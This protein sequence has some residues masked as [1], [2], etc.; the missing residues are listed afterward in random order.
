MVSSIPPAPADARISGVVPVAPRRISVVSLLSDEVFS[1][2]D[3][4][5]ADV[6]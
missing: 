5:E 1:I 2:E 6:G 3:D 4:G